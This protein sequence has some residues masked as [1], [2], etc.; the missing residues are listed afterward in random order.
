MTLW[1]S[2]L[3]YSILPEFWLIYIEFIMFVL[4]YLKEQEKKLTITYTYKWILH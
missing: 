3:H 2:F 4:F 1:S